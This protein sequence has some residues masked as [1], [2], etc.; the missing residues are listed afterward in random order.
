MIVAVAFTVLLWT[1]KRNGDWPSYEQTKGLD[2]G[3]GQ[4]VKEGERIAIPEAK[5]TTPP[6]ASEEMKEKEKDQ[7]KAAPTTK[8]TKVES[9][10]ASPLA[11]VPNQQTKPAPAESVP[12]IVLP[13]RKPISPTKII[14]D[15]GEDDIHPVAPPGRQ[16]LPADLPA[17]PT[18][19]HWERQ[20]EHFPVP[21]ES[22]IHLPTG[23]PIQIPR[24]QHQF[25]D[26]TPD[27]KINRQKR[28]D[29][30]REEFRRAWNGYKTKAWMHDE[31]SPVSGKFRDPFCGWA[32]TLVDT[33]DTLWIM[34]LRE[35][36]EEAAKAVDLIDFTTSP[37][38]DIPVFETTI[39]Y[40]GGL[41]AAYDVSGAAYKNLLDKAIELAE[42]LM[43][44]F[45]TPNRMPDLY[46]RWKPTFASQPHRAG[47]RS[48]LAE[49]GSLSLE[50]TRLAQITKEPRYYD[51]IARITIALS[52]WQDR[53]TMLDGVF[54]DN[55]DASGCNRTQVEELLP[56]TSGREQ[57]V[58]P[59]KPSEE[60]VGFQPVV[61]DMEPSR[62][63]TKTKALAPGPGILEMD[64]LPGVPGKAEIKGW[65][66][67]NK[68]MKRAPLDLPDG[69]TGTNMTAQSVPS[70]KPTTDPITG[71]PLDI[72]A[73]Q[74]AIGAGVGGWD[75]VPQ[76][77]EPASPH[78]T[79]KFSM[80]GGQDSTYEYFPK[81]CT[82][83]IVSCI[84][85]L[86]RDSNI[87]FLEVL[88]IR[89]KRCILKR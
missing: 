48:N 52:D 67:K 63:T 11:A 40:L 31:L 72:P 71:L 75:C 24:I 39:R 12:Q 25:N 15:D 74:A 46:Y 68:L 16:E 7:L 53:G 62:S 50:F 58:F 69:L 42:I 37:R 19:I 89:I 20:V 82:S 4:G 43:G 83:V 30:V 55:V 78:G 73:A 35:D 29:N 87:C 5:A 45:D 38:A 49:L 36:F 81:V 88:M 76:G 3:L 44:I 64:V 86:I 41:L 10:P 54:P 56:H 70:P 34:G 66:D 84:V 18:I 65:D 80:G 9:K 22:L 85:A 26:E 17:E 6:P 21:K 59:A 51:A 33:L 13:D 77:L 57:A 1:L 2:L 60:P 32:A 27:A 28:Q 47:Q 23:A 79:N 14:D 8:P 61:P